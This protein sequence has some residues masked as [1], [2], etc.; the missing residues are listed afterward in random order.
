MYLSL[1]SEN[2]ANN[3]YSHPIASAVDF[4]RCVLFVQAFGFIIIIIIVC[5]CDGEAHVCK[6]Y[7]KRPEDSLVML[8]LSFPL[9]M[10]SAAQT[11]VVRLA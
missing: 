1:T 6:A 8:L 2:I 9:H 10:C 3:S 11:P 7:E 5:V 4:N